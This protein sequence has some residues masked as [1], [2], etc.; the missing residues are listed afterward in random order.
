MDEFIELPNNYA[1]KSAILE[2]L[3]GLEK[4]LEINKEITQRE[5][6]E[7]MMRLAA[8]YQEEKT[9]VREEG[10]QIGKAEGKVEG[11]VNL[12]LRQL[13]R[14]LGD[15]SPELTS[16]VRQ[17][18]LAQLEILGEMLLEFDNQQDLVNWLRG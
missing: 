6:R 11:E 4:N 7:L 15:L 5:D 12:I 17:L 3:Y 16:Q 9:R 10:Y 18:N 8:L 1:V 14:K 13:S 2:I